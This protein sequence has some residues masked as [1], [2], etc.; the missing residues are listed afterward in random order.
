M[1]DAFDIMDMPRRFD[2]DQKA[3]HRR[4]IELSAA[5]HPDRFTDALDQADA[6]E[7]AAAINEAYRTLSDPERRAGA[8]LAVL[9]GAA[10]EDD[11]SLPPNLLMEMMEVRERMEE[12]IA[13]DDKATLAELRTWAEGQR[14][15]YLDATAKLFD[16]A[17]RARAEDAGADVSEALGAVRM[18]LNAL[19]YF[20]RML[21]QMP[22]T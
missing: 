20:E 16:E 18:Q 5:H 22:A 12:A 19:R 1:R 15:A 17:L 11:K 8:L 9:G 21:E 10:K 14:R 4:F 13:E 7:R 6:A 3:L 2:L